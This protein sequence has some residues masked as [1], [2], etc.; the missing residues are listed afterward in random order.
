MKRIKIED[1]KPL[2]S[3]VRDLNEKQAKKIHGGKSNELSL[4]CP[5]PISPSNPPR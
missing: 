3:D 1:L 4:C 5:D 2:N